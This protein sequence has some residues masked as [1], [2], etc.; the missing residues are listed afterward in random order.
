[1]QFINEENILDY[2]FVNID[3]LVCPVKAVCVDFHGYTDATRFFESPKKAKILGKQGI[4]WVFPYYSVWAWMSKSSQV[5]NEQVL[6]VVYR[7]LQISDDTP[8]I[9]TGGSM[10]GLTAL[11]YLVYGKRQ[12]AACAAN[13]PVTDMT[14]FFDIVP[15]ARRA[16]LSAHIMD[17]RPLREIMDVYSPINL[18][19]KFPAIPYFL[20]YGEKDDLITKNFMHQMIEKMTEA[21]CN[22]SYLLEKNMTHCNIDGHKDA[23]AAWCN[24]I[25]KNAEKFCLK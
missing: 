20:I 25:I 18:I 6:D 10:G 16:I 12:V 1:M 15:D 11:C 13:C 21:G 24:F 22:V 17:E 7:K 9:I 3:T 8:L 19:D 5:F 23:F 4:V 14:K 2:A